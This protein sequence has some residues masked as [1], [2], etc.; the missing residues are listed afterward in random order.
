MT[1]RLCQYGEKV[2]GLGGWLRGV[3]DSRK[4][5]RIPTSAIVASVM[6]MFLSHRKSIN[7]VDQDLKWPKRLE[8]IIGPV[9][10]S[11]D[12]IGEVVALIAPEDLRQ[13]LNSMVYTLTRN[14]VLKNGWS[15]RF[16]A[17]D[18]H[19]L[20]KSRVIHCDE[21]SQ[22][23]IEEK[24][25]N[26]E[27]E[28][29]IEYYHR[30]VVAH[31]IGFDVAVPLDLEL[32]VPGEGEV[33]AGKRL[34][35]RVIKN[36]PRLFDGV[37]GDAMYFEAPMI[38]FCLAHGKHVVFTAKGDHRL[39]IQ[40]ADG[41]FSKMQPELWR[42]HSRQTIRLWDADGFTSSEGVSVPLRVLRAEE[43]TTRRLHGTEDWTTRT[44]IM[45]FSWT[46]DMPRSL[47]PTRQLWD[48]GHHRWD[49]ED[50]LF[51]VL[52]NH[53]A[54]DHSYH[55]HPVAIVN[56]LL[57]LF[58]SFVLMESFFKRNLKPQMR[59]RFTLLA[60]RDAIHAEI[61]C[62]KVSVSWISDA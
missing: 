22:R 49:I 61:L 8:K 36:H 20:F 59:S 48:I 46:T 31:L 42:K 29:F 47:L 32:L 6:T 28:T 24:K 58:I 62:G 51:N 2:F 60:L 4:R 14:K 17:I 41:L 18:G 26:G 12:R 13:M 38:D 40:D 53:W 27:I 5:P 21:C 44:D 33:S 19:E 54:M 11:G 34:L 30:C 35:S 56:F 37:V 10:P 57:I 23:R 9:K 25:S 45:T 1:S 55:H 15:M 43:T 7:A 3:S 50:D 52:V 16:V 39:L